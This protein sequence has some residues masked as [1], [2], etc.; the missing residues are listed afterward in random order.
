MVACC[1]RRSSGRGNISYRQYQPLRS[2]DDDP[3][4]HSSHGGSE[5]GI[6]MSN[7]GSSIQEGSVRGPGRLSM[8][9]SQHGNSRK[10]GL[11]DSQH[12][13]QHGSSNHGSSRH[14]SNFQSRVSSEHGSNSATSNEVGD[15]GEEWVWGEIRNPMNGSRNGSMHGDNND[16]DD[17]SD[18][19]SDSDSDLSGDAF[20]IAPADVN[21]GSGTW[22]K[23]F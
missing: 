20:Q 15:V 7:T 2:L 8:E 13:S 21:H 18:T 6:E 22:L 10:S 1:S 11:E 19:D 23:P 14:G 9:M 5:R 12:G 3:S 17:I 4:H 16:E